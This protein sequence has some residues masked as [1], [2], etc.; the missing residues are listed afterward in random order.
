MT[1]S[2]QLTAASSAKANPVRSIIPALEDNI[3]MYMPSGVTTITPSQ[4]GRPVTVCVEVESGAVDELEKQRK[5]LTA[6]G[7]KPFFSLQ[8]K[9]GVAAFWPDKF[10]WDTR[11]DA[12]GS[13]ATG[14]WASGEWTDSGRKAVE[15]KD[16]RTFSPT[17]HVDAI[18]D[19]PDNP[20]HVI[21]C[22]EAKANMGALENDPAFQN[23]SPLW[24][25]NA[26]QFP[27]SLPGNAGAPG[28]NNQR[29]T[30]KETVAELQARNQKL[31]L[32]I[33]GLNQK[34]DAL[35]KAELKAASAE[36]REIAVQIELAQA[37]E[38]TTAL[39]AAN[40]KRLEGDAEAA[41]QRMV[42]AQKIAPRDT[43]VQASYK[44]KFMKDPDLIP[45]LAPLD[46]AAPNG[47]DPLAGRTTPNAAALDASGKQRKEYTLTSGFD[48]DGAFRAYGELVAANANVQIDPTNRIHSYQ[49]KG[50]LALQAASFYKTEL[51]TNM[52]HWQD[53]TVME[54]GRRVGFRQKSPMS[55]EIEC[56]GHALE[57]AD[58]TDN[59][60]PVNVLGVLSG[61]LVL[62]RTLPFF[63]Y[64]YPEL[65]NFYTDFSDTPGLLNQTETTRIVTQQA[66]Q[67][68]NAATDG[69][70]RPL[71][72]NTVSPAQTTDVSLTLTDYVAVP[73]N[74]GQNVL[75][76][77]TRRLFDEQSVLAIKALAGY[78]V[79]MLTN[80]ATA[81]TYN[82]YATIAA[83]DPTFANAPTY[84]KA[85]GDFSMG[86]LDTLD[87]MFTT[88]KVPEEDRGIMLKPTYYAK[89]RGDPRLSFM[90][91]ASAKDTTNQAGEFLTEARLPK[92]S[93]FAP[94]KAPYLPS[95]TPSTGA[96]TNNIVFFAFQK[97]AAI[98]KS[99]LPQE[100]TQTLGVMIPGSVTTV[101][102]PD[103]KI[104]IML[105]QY[106]N[107]QGG[108]AEWRPEV[109]LGAAAGDV[110]AGIVGTSA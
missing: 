76:A 4:N 95:S 12:T 18:R 93:G 1:T 20:V 27:A 46:A 99:R 98:I 47:R 32:T 43:E 33:A 92:L 56:S 48:F 101:T 86:D 60:A 107:L 7:K 3:C 45:L 87:A 90:Y 40:A 11:I 25:G 66:V 2:Y 50:K 75:G 85:Y 29:N 24:A 52:D 68:Y 58:Y 17:F 54:I 49:L 53:C 62:Q 100:F 65:L 108:W 81:A 15:G 96:T 5:V 64:K 109:I 26:K 57:A 21:C 102:D 35:S 41:V 82:S 39:E 13:M 14:I 30:M 34:T 84:V 61:T 97:A 74:F 44:A 73:I 55:R 19:D 63:A 9:E 28:N 104:S 88:L 36:S 105:V 110:R 83:T 38:K 79:N 8:H 77:T 71:G 23:M 59:N 37:Q 106:V 31:E 10:F 72:W 42:K 67:K 69:T 78:F 91:A 70:G 6:S 22:E 103:T 89:L 94:Y 51:A 80:L 16:F